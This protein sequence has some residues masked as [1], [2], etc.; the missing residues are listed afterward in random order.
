MRKFIVAVVLMLGVVFIL[1]RFSEVQAIIDTLQRGDWKFILLGLFAVA[2]YIFSI[3]ACFQSIYRAIGLDEKIINLFPV[4]AAAIFLSTVAP[5]GGV[6]GMAVF[7][8]E[9]HKK[10]YSPVRAT[11]AGALYAVFDYAAFI[12]YLALG[13]VVLIRRNNLNAGE[14]SASIILVLIA[15]TLAFLVYLGMKSAD[16][17][18]RVLVWMA[19]LVNRILRPFTHRAYL[20][21]QRAYEFAHEASSGLLELERNPVKL[22]APFIITLVKQGIMVILL[23]LAFLA[24]EVKVS[25]GTV[26]A[27]YSIG[28]LFTLISP[29]PLGIG[30]VE[31]LLSL[32]LASMY[33]PLE[34]A[35]VVALVYRAFTLWIPLLIGIFAFRWLQRVSRSIE[36]QAL[37]GSEKFI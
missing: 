24:F 29:T 36:K 9:A 28:Y 18:A 31:G 6:S 4:S 37:P 12:C 35:T 20:S 13:L 7:V 14:I 15:I 17:F 19:R 27:G 8:D 33:V 26:I 21:E 16:Q 22:V 1:W 30:F 25:P 3:A 23:W 11:V 34:A 32:V 10:G 2:A 5:S